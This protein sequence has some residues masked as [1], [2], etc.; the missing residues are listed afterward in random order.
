MQM[1]SQTEKNLRFLQEFELSLSMAQGQT[2]R[3]AKTDFVFR[4][5]RKKNGA[6]GRYYGVRIR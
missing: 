4:P 5:V 1:A 6:T 3:F 2:K